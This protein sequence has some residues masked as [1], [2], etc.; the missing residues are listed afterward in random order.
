LLSS[1]LVAALLLALLVLLLAACRSQPEPVTVPTPTARPTAT[2]VPVVPS[3]RLDGS[4]LTPVELSG[5]FPIE[6]PS[7][8][9]RTVVGNHPMYVETEHFRIHY[10]LEGANA[11]FSV[12]SDK[13]GIPDVVQEVAAAMEYSWWAEIEVFGWPAPVPDVRAGGDERYDV[14]LINLNNSNAGQANGDGAEFDNPNTPSIE[15]HASSSSIEIDIETA[16]LSPEYTR[17]VAAHEFMHAIQFGLDGEESAS[18]LWEAT[19]TWMEDEILDDYNSGD[20]YLDSFFI[21]PHGCLI[22]PG[23]ATPPDVDYRWYASWIILRYVSEHYGHET[24]RTLWENAGTLERWDAWDATLE[25]LGFTFEDMLFDFSLAILTRDFEEGEN[26]PVVHLEGELAAGESFTPSIGVAPTGMQFVEI[27][28]SHPVTVRLDNDELTGYLVG[29]R[30]GQASL[31]P[32]TEGRATADGFDYDHLYAGLVNLER[33][34]F[35]AR[36][37][38]LTYTLTA[39]ENGAPEAPVALRNA[40]NFVAP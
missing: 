29:I 32:F 35:P 6:V 12:D 36:C 8:P 23:G 26:Y 24:I 28:S 2:D 3:Q 18:W 33:P 9:V 30:D 39:E 21:K 16:R 17:S 1:F 7:Y 34:L 38:P 14:Y 15:T 5:P 11:V 25:P 20:W 40:A 27:H 31:F 37:T 22:D 19:A 13:D 10:A 4:N